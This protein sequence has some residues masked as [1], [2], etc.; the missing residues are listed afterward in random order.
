VD[1]ANHLAVPVGDQEGM[2]GLAQPSLDVFNGALAGFK[3]G[4]PAANT[5]VVNLGNRR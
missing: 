1:P 4:R 2:V 3:R 5:L